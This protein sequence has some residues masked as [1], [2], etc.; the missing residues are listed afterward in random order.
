MLE[1]YAQGFIEL[2]T[3]ASCAVDIIPKMCSLK[4][5]ASLWQSDF[6][7]KP[8]F[9]EVLVGPEVHRD[10]S[11][12]TQYV[13]CGVWWMWERG[14]F[15][16]R[17]FN[18]NLEPSQIWPAYDH[19]MFDSER[20]VIDPLQNLI[21]SVSRASETS[22][23]VINPGRDRTIF[24]VNIQLVVSTSLSKHA[25]SIIGVQRLECTHIFDES[26]TYSVFIVDQ[27]AICGERIVVLYY[28]DETQ[29]LFIQVIDWKKG[30]AKHVSAFYSWK[31]ILSQCS[32]VSFACTRWTRGKVPST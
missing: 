10:Y 9:E 15:F 11:L 18:A 6:L 27:P 31:R 5:L 21:I 2:E 19:P 26:R 32:A 25:S 23:F 20:C 24:L 7:A 12:G 22:F 4:K 16:V 13:K 30:H 28:I 8:V 1:V 29:E 17:E 3:D 14:S